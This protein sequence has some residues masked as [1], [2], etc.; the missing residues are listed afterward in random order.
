[1]TAAAFSR[2][3]G[4][5]NHKWCRTVFWRQGRFFIT[6]QTPC[7]LSSGPLHLRAYTVG[8]FTVREELLWLRQDVKQAAAALVGGTADRTVSVAWKQATQLTDLCGKM[9]DPLACQEQ[10]PALRPGELFQG[11]LVQSPVPV[12][13]GRVHLH[14]QQHQQGQQQ[15]NPVQGV[16]AEQGGGSQHRWHCWSSWSWLMPFPRA[17]APHLASAAPLQSGDE[18]SSV[19]VGCLQLRF[20]L[21]STL[22]KTFTSWVSK[23]RGRAVD[24]SR[25]AAAVEEQTRSALT[26]ETA[27]TVSRPLEPGHKHA[28]AS[29]KQGTV[30]ID[31]IG[32]AWGGE[33]LAPDIPA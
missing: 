14:E 33:P 26:P 8:R 25:V 5:N 23:L 28:C 11:G 1:M 19:I 2:I 7:G 15:H 10:Q 21:H 32:Y 20:S 24:S 4:Q 6:L 30:Q 29:M 31:V 9:Q 22:R 13:G 16:P 18:D 12:Q 3:E 27:S 17:V